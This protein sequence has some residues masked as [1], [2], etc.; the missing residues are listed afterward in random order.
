MGLLDDLK[1]LI[2]KQG[3]DPEPSPAPAPDPAPDPAPSPSPGP[4]PAP[5]PAPAVD[6]KVGEL[7]ALVQQQQTQLAEQAEAMKLLAQ[8]PGQPTAVVPTAPPMPKLHDEAGLV[9]RLEHEMK[10]SEGTGIPANWVWHNP[11]KWGQ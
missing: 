9:K 5:D 1:E 11:N 10:D 6:P 7:E 3:G 2:N 8:R 4:D